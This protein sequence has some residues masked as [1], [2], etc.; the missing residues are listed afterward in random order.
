MS[1][2]RPFFL[3][4]ATLLLGTT[5]LFSK[6][7][8]IEVTPVGYGA[9]EVGQIGNGYF[10][11]PNALTTDNISHVWQQ[12]AFCILGYKARLQQHLNVEVTGG[13][14]IAYS[15]P[16]IGLLPTTMKKREFFFIQSAFAELPL[17]DPETAFWQ[18]RIGYFP[19]KY[20]PDAR[21]LGEYMFRTNTYP[22]VIYSDFDYPQANLLG[23][24][25]K[26]ELFNKLI[27]N[28]LLLHSEMSGVPEQLWSV[29]D[30]AGSNLFDLFSFSS[31]ISFAH[32]L[33]VYQGNGY[34]D[35]WADR[36][37][38]DP[39]KL[40][41]D[42]RRS[43]ID[44]IY[45][46]TDTS[47]FDWKAIKI[48]ARFSFDPKKFIPL[49]I[50][51]RNDLRLYAEGNVIGL[52]NYR[53]YYRH[54][55]D[56]TL[57]TAGF[58]VPGFTFIDLISVE[59]EYCANRL[60]A[61]SDERYFSQVPVPLPISYSEINLNRNPWRWSVYVKKS[62]FNE[63]TSIIAQVARD[64]KKINFHYFDRPYMSFIET[65]PD[66]DNWWWTFKTEFKF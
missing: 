40:N 65:L 49:N 60:Y 47:Y 4:S 33:N 50:F 13:G 22:L 25:V 51:G 19:F 58:N 30:I 8:E 59:G 44:T 1:G 61:Y 53:R 12:Q 56:R 7:K 9:M 2:I 11:R 37:F 18:F 34:L 36:F 3:L 45:N 63:H 48:M 39:R 55:E 10:K 31:G 41:P 35:Q 28:D 15:T 57:V 29:S 32:Y 64:H 23:V 62:F 24:Q 52:K 43:Y 38:G 46:E 20:N 21:N 5:A 14:L 27:T 54:I 26:T 66:G 42:E 16:Q 17:G 6:E